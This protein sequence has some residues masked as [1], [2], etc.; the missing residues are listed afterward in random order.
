MESIEPSLV[1]MSRYFILFVFLSA[2][3]K[4]YGK[5]T[6]LVETIRSFDL[7]PTRLVRLCAYA[8]CIAETCIVMLLA[9]GEQGVKVGFL[10]SSIVLF[11]F[12]FA[13]S[14]VLVRGINTTCTCFGSSNKNI[15]F[16]E[17]FRNSFMLVVSITGAILSNTTQS[18]IFETIN[19]PAF[20]PS[21][22]TATA[23]ALVLIKL[24]GIT[25]RTDI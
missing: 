9:L 22:L 6:V 4:K 20:L 14:S 12:L 5:F 24:G 7:L 8:V 13:V 21:F 3:V 15:G 1:L 16:Y 25:V 11:I 18:V 17:I 2:I 23:L 10:L 19:L